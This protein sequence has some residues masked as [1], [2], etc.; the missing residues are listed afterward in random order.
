MTSAAGRSGRS[1]GVGPDS[2]RLDA[3][4]PDRTSAPEVSGVEA[5]VG[6]TPGPDGSSA[7]GGFDGNSSAPDGSDLDDSGFGGFAGD[8]SGPGSFG[9]DSSGLGGIVGDS[10]G[11]D[12]R[13]PTSSE[14]DSIDPDTSGPE[15]SGS[16][17]GLVTSTGVA[18]GRAFAVTAL[19]SLPG[20][21]VSSSTISFSSEVTVRPNRSPG[22]RGRAG[23]TERFT[24]AVGCAAR[25]ETALGSAAGSS[26]KASTTGPTVTLS[27]VATRTRPRIRS[28]LTSV[29]FALPRSSTNQ[30]LPFSTTRACR[31]EMPASSRTTSFSEPLPSVTSG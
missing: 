31:R 8:S 11:L 23:R 20:S 2:P 27:P 15:S 29:P 19:G 17:P 4:E 18:A 13:G 22:D 12:A 24:F 25:A 28:P 5:P 30:P 26:E 14:L 7:P 9:H 3:S 21:V 6:D 10:S 16:S 1:T